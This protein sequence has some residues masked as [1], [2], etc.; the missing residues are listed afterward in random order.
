MII[1][2]SN[3]RAWERKPPALFL[4]GLI[5]D[6]PAGIC[7]F[8]VIRQRPDANESVRPSKAASGGLETRHV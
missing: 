2:Q 6:S 3:L 8:P 1:M 5:R 4:P 7:R